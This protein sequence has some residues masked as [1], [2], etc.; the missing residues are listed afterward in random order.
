MTPRAER[1]EVWLVD[2]GLIAKV[3][4]ALIF[5]VRPGDTDRELVSVVPH[6][7]SVRGS[8]FEVPIPVRF[9]RDGAFDAQGIVTIPTVRLVRRLGRLDAAQIQLVEAGVA[10]WLGLPPF[11]APSPPR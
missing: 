10:N 3:R 2:L 11:A 4:P 7:T 5:S 1:G 8:R 6:T 9:L